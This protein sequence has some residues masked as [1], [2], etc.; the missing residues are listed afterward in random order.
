MAEAPT[1]ETNPAPLLPM[2]TALLDVTQMGEADRL[3]VEAGL[4]GI[5][6]MENAGASVARAILARWTPCPVLVLCGPGNNGGD[7]FVAARHLQDAGWT[8]RVA[9]LGAREDLRGEAAYHAERWA[10]GVEPLTPAALDGAELV[11]D[12]V[13]G[14]G[15][16][17]AV[18][19]PAAQTLAALA[20]SGLPVVAVDIPSGVMGNTGE[21]LG[22]VAAALTVTFF[23]KKPGHLLLPGRSLCGEVVVADIGT[24]LAVLTTIRPDTFEND[25]ALWLAQLPRPGSGSNKYLRG[26]ALISGG[27]PMTGAARMAARAAARIGAG[28]TTIAV[29]EIALPIYAAALTSIM[30][31]PIDTAAAFDHLLT[32]QRIS[33]FL[34][35]PGAGV[36][37]GTKA[38]ANSILATGRATVLD[39]DAITSFQG[40]V[41]GLAAA[42]VGPCVMTPH[43]GEFL[44]LFAQSGDKLMRARAA[45]R[46]SGAVIVVKGADTVI[47][48]PDGRAIVNANAPPTLATAGAGD[49]LSGIVLGLLAQGMDPFLAAAAAVWLHGAAAAAFGP[50]LLAEDLPDLLPAVLQGLDPGSTAKRRAPCRP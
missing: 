40:D 48:A 21:D 2:G 47:A 20:S 14:A 50:G 29:P 36:G 27:Y 41:D 35:G 28:L 33:A 1:V 10:G 26:H 6:M 16:S 11:V 13:F 42:I 25:P 4:S 18:Q 15:L 3:T 38:R 32:D 17:R 46:R 39:A 34:I 9:L 19:G 23:R 7:G 37:D 22:A 45:A 30:V 31:Q 49:V 43:E 12:A 24:P 5:M 8:V 44:R